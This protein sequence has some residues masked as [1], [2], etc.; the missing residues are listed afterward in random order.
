M[1]ILIKLVPKGYGTGGA[2]ALL[3]IAVILSPFYHFFRYMGFCQHKDQIVIE[4]TVCEG[5]TWNNNNDYLNFSIDASFGKEEVAHFTTHTLV[6]KDDK[7]IGYIKSEF[8]GTSERMEDN[9]PIPYFET[10][11]SQKLYFHISHPTNASWEF[12]ELFKELYDGNLESFK[13]VTNIIYTTFT[14]STTVGHFLLLPNDF[15]YDENGIIHYRDQ[16]SDKIKYYYYDDN[17]RKHYVK[18]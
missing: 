13:F 6:F 16:L 1:L 14:D 4:Q 3:V 17:G 9:T 12:Y 10:H 7:Y 11:S 8:S 5:F 15:Y 18:T 2:V